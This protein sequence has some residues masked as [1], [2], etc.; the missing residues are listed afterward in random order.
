MVSQGAMIGG[1]LSALAVAI[2]ISVLALQGMTAPISEPDLAL[3]ANHTLAP[4]APAILS[5][6]EIF[7]MT[8]S[9]VV[10]IIVQRNE[11]E[12][13]PG[14]V[15]SGIVFDKNGH[16]V[17]NAHVV[18]DAIKTEVTFLDGRTYVADIVGT[19]KHTDLAVVMVDTDPDLLMPI[20]VGN[21]STMRVGEDVAAIGN[22]F[23]LSGSMTAGIISQIDR[24]LLVE[25]TGFSIPD[26]IQTDAAINPGNSGGPLLNMRGEV[27]GVNTAIQTNTGEFN[28]IGFAVPSQTLA[29]IVPT[30]ITEGKYDHPWIGV[31]GND[32]SPALAQA[33]NLPDTRGFL[34]RDVV[35]DS[36]AQSAGVMGSNQTIEYDGN[37]YIVGGDIVMMVDDIKVRKISDILIYLQRSKA[38]G[39]DMRLQVLRDGVLIDLTLVLDKRPE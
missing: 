20:R 27:I 22:P 2:L 19:D 30:I 33:L 11:T 36:P 34:V 7:E 10:R 15:G 26:V 23:G 5:L 32:I 18:E 38:V 24:L 14:G 29:K 17:T 25:E 16:I 6:V 31:S 9:G 4:T 39:D 21:S 13:E 35:E 28:G 8:E 3:T 1:G 37:E 12:S